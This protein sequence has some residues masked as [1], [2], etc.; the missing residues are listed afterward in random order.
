MIRDIH[1]WK[2]REMATSPTK[3]L[4]NGVSL[5][6][7]YFEPE[8]P[9]YPFIARYLFPSDLFTIR[10]IYYGMGDNTKNSSAIEEM[11]EV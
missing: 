3:W 7:S 9:H 5:A 11:A 4:W 8:M 2:E 1:S 6:K 10:L